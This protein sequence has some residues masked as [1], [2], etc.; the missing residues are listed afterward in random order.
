M[1]GY[2]KQFMIPFKGL[3]E[4]K[5]EFSF[6]IG[7]AFFEELD[8]SILE[9]GNVSIQL[10]MDK[11]PNMLVFSFDITGTI[12]LQCDRC[13]EVYDQPVEGNY[14]L[15][16]KFT[17]RETNKPSED[18]VILPEDAHE[19][20]VG[21]YIYEYISLL[22]PIKHVH[23]HID[24]CNQEMIDMLNNENEDNNSSKEID[25]RWKALEEIRNNMK[26]N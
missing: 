13:L 1:K 25:E 9:D 20:D 6:K 16:A 12:K 21:H 17:E 15:I 10:E 26:N 4:G 5:H 19:F 18:I 11:K 24:N 3:K 22:L 23:E 7:R 14:M 2:W 8:Y